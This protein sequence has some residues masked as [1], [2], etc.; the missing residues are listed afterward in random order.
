[1]NTKK[2]IKTSAPKKRV[3]K[4]RNSKKKKFKTVRDFGGRCTIDGTHFEDGTCSHGHQVGQ[5]I[6]VP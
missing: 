6:S 5:Q 1:M 4:T 3:Q 2:Q